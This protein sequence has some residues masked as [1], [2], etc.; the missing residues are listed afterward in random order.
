MLEKQIF[1]SERP[2]LRRALHGG[3]RNNRPRETAAKYLV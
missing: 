2:V 1:R 3:L